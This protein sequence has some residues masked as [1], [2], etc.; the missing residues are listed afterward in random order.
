MSHSPFISFVV[1]ATAGISVRVGRPQAI[2]NAAPT[3][4]SSDILTSKERGGG[5]YSIPFCSP[6]YNSHGENA[7]YPLG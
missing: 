4:S 5:E 3:C 1:E 7:A 6:R 2:C